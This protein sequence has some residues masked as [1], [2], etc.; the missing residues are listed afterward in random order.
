M[1]VPRTI[2]VLALIAVFAA[3]TIPALAQQAPQATADPQQQAKPQPQTQDPQQA[4]PQTQDSQASSAGT[5][6]TFQGTISHSQGQYVL[7]DP[8]SGVSYQLDDQKKAKS[9]SGKS[10]KVTGT[11]DASSHMIRVA[12]IEP[13]S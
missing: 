7:T 6:Q 9:F 3:M 4:Q 10:V 1:K 13:G 5:L 12:S 8:A 11:M 2:T